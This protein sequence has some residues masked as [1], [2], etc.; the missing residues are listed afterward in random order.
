MPIDRRGSSDGELLRATRREPE[1]F[2]IVYERHIDVI[3]RYLAR[4]SGNR[5]VGLELAAETFA[6]AL[7]SAHRFRPP[8]DGSAR[9]W[10][11]GIA[12]NLLHTYQR[13]TQ[14]ETRARMRLGI[15]ENTTFTSGYEPSLEESITDGDN[16]YERVQ[17]AM[18]G[19]PAEQRLAIELRV[20]SELPYEEIAHRLGCTPAAAR[21]RVSRALAAL[22]AE[23][24]EDE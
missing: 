10:L 23:L 2:G 11:F 21:T 16:Q 5:E 13:R 12:A 7:A 3:F 17:A 1:A 9:P 4:E 15:L 18:N 14:I 19:L 24:R 20:S 8:A 6:R 22:R